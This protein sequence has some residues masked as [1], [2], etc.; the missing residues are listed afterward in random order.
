MLEVVAVVGEVEGRPA[1][2]PGDV[3]RKLWVVV[4][5][6]V[7]GGGRL[8]AEMAAAPHPDAPTPCERPNGP[9]SQCDYDTRPFA[10]ASG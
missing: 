3:S 5:V 10:G 8:W 9:R 7:V 6:V 2:L 4:V 1:E